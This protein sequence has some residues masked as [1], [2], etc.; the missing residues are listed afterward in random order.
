MEAFVVPQ[1]SERPIPGNV[2]GSRGAEVRFIHLFIHSLGQQSS[3]VTHNVPG[4]MVCAGV[5][6]LNIP[7]GQPDQTSIMSGG[8]EW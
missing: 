7:E 8:D 4:P 6:A 2:R 5:T 3:L 1:G